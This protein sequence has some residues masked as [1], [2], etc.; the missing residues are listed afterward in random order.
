MKTDMTVLYESCL[1]RFETLKSRN[2][3][4]KQYDKVSGVYGIYIDEPAI[5]KCIP[6]CI[7]KSV[8]IK[9]HFS[10]Q[11]REIKKLLEKAPEEYNKALKFGHSDYVAEKFCHLLIE[12]AKS[13]EQLQ[14]VLIKQCDEEE[15]QQVYDEKIQFYGADEFGMNMPKVRRDYLRTYAVNSLRTNKLWRNDDAREVIDNYLMPLISYV[16]EY[17]EEK[18]NYGFNKVNYHLVV[19]LCETEIKAWRNSLDLFKSTLKYLQEFN[20]MVEGFEKWLNENQK[21]W[22]EERKHLLKDAMGIMISYKEYMKE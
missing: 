19:K 10:V 6:I 20:C 3:D 2:D 13:M 18:F 12:Y 15:L 16:L 7:F 9:Y 14:F 17:D 21:G 4:Y 8:N 22:I 11:K 1:H 5:E